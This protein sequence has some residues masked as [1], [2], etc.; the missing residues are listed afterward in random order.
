MARG[1]SMR[2]SVKSNSSCDSEMKEDYNNKM[3][4]WTLA[5]N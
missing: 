2:Y 1:F 4:S 5:I 3:W